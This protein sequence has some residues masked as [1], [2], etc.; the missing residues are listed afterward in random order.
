MRTFQFIQGA[1]GF[2]VRGLWEGLSVHGLLLQPVHGP[3]GLHQGHG[4]GLIVSS[5]P[6]HLNPPLFGRSA[7]PSLISVR[8]FVGKGHRARPM[9]PV[10]HRNQPGLF[11]SRTIPVRAVSR[12]GTQETNFEGFPGSGVG[13]SLPLQIEDFLSYDRQSVILWRSLLGRLSFRNHLVPGSHLR[14]RSL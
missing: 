3:S 2:S 1:G 8:G 9:S 11:L 13:S 4:S 14:M 12:H 5:Q 10:G 7:D 6:W